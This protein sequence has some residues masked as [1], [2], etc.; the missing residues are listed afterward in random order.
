MSFLRGHHPP[1]EPRLGDLRRSYLT[2]GDL[3]R[4]VPGGIRGV[5]SDPA[6]GRLGI[7]LDQVSATL[8]TEGIATFTDAFIALM[9][10]LAAK[11]DDL[12]QAR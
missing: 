5:T 6:M 10:V 12:V 2:G 7:N 1:W 9:G 8:E 4:C 11:V 3:P